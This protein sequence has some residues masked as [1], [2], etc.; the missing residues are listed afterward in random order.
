DVTQLTRGLWDDWAQ[1]RL[2]EYVDAVEIELRRTGV[3]A[4][5]ARRYLEHAA[6][7]AGSAVLTGVQTGLR[8]GLAWA[9]KVWQRL[10]RRVTRPATVW[11]PLLALAIVAV[12]VV[13][14]YYRALVQGG[15]FL[16][17]EFALHSALLVLIAWLVPFLLDRLLQP[18]LER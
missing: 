6:R 7:S 5:P 4:A 18:S 11:L 2:G 10:L 12:Q 3:A 16:G 1:A 17:V 13:L 15:P 9:G 14:G 8:L